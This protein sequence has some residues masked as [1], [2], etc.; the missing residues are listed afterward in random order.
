MDKFNLNLPLP[1]F[2]A[3]FLTP[4]TMK[5]LNKFFSIPKECLM[6]RRVSRA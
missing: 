4:H 5:L 2:Y 3:F 6:I 1:S